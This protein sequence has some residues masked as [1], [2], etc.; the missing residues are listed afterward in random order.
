MSRIFAAIAVL[1]F[2]LSAV[3]AH[4][5]PRPMDWGF[6]ALALSLATG[7]WGWTPWKKTS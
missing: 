1:F 5:I 6:V 2:F 7:G 4:I 3:G